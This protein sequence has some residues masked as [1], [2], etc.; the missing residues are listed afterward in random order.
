M[1]RP[2]TWLTIVALAGGVALGHAAATGKVSPPPATAADSEPNSPADGQEPNQLDRTVLPIP[3]PKYP[4]ITELDARNA[5]APP[6]FE[7]KAP[8]KARRTCSSC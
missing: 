3:E 6:R 5:K 4:P 2:M 7:V 8:A 1:K